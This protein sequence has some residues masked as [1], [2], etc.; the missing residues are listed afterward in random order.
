MAVFFLFCLSS[1]FVVV[2][3]V[4]LSF[5]W[6]HCWCKMLWTKV[7]ATGISPSCYEETEEEE[8]EEG[9]RILLLLIHSLLLTSFSDD[10]DDDDENNNDDDDDDD[11]SFINNTTACAEGTYGRDCSRSCDCA[12]NNTE[13]CD[14][15]NGTCYCKAGWEGSTCSVVKDE[16]QLGPC[17]G[18]NEHCV[19]RGG[20]YSCVC[21]IGFQYDVNGSCVGELPFWVLCRVSGRLILNPQSPCRWAVD[22]GSR[23]G[24]L[25]RVPDSWSK[26][27]E[28]ESRQGRR[29][30]FLLQSYLFCADSYSVS[31][32][33][34]VT[35]VAH[36]RPRPFCQ[37]V[38]V[39]G[40]T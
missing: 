36:K 16:C 35:A 21:N 26:G 28:F 19:I 11:V 29:E 22:R 5:Y 14:H 3:E 6:C 7:W 37:K 34:R 39:V 8:W 30:N 1:H 2:L 13:S 9:I 31:V 12:E 15:V 23:D 32:S 25:I 4:E 24:L 38:Q 20:N 27:C 10:D 33:P 17:Q 40:Y 18:Q